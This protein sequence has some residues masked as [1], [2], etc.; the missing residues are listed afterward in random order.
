MPALKVSEIIGVRSA[1]TGKEVKG[2]FVACPLTARQMMELPEAYVMKKIIQA[3]RK[4]EELGA[5]DRRPGSVH[6]GGR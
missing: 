1:A 5:Q 6:L 3:A 4:A 2:W